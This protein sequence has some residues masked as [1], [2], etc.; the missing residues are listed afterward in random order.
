MCR[1]TRGLFWTG[2]YPN[3]NQV[4]TFYSIDPVSELFDTT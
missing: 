1:Y 2:C 4:N 3:L